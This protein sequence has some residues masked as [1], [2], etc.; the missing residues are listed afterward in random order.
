MTLARARRLALDNRREIAEGR[1]PRNRT[2][3]IPTF[4]A[5]AETVI[6]LHAETWKDSGKS[7]AQWR[8]SLRDYAMPRLGRMSVASIT[9]ADVLAV[10]MPIWNTKRETARRVRQ[11][12]GAVMKWAIA[13]GHRND[14]PA[15]EAIGAALPKNGGHRL[16]QR[17]LP[18][19][20]VASALETVR[21]SQAYI[22][23]RLAF[24]FLVLTA[25]RSGEV[26]GARWN[27]VDLEARTWTIPA[28]RMKTM[29]GHRVPLSARALEVLHDARLYADDSEL[30]F[31]SVT[32]RAL[33]DSTLSKLVRELG[34][35]AVPHGFRSSFRQ[36]AAER[37]NFAREVCEEALAHVNPNRVEAAYQ[38]SD[39]FDRRRE[40][41]D[42]WARYVT[43]SCCES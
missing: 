13:E 36:W 1:D 18:H 32:G 29:R 10:L 12:I 6:A 21:A 7:A 43:A 39:L 35:Q 4:D 26:R 34:I 40:L 5:A 3:G 42:Q 20:R 23:T 16:H 37:T 38:R 8:A 30:V 31:P 24:E 19:D 33:S 15:G 25:T 2:G 22:L 11:R 41:M 17:A 28:A 9:S 14:N 27:E